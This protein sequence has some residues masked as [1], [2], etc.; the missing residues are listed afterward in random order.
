MR[1][2]TQKTEVQKTDSQSTLSLP[3]AL[4]VTPILRLERPQAFRFHIDEQIGLPLP[5]LIKPYEKMHT[6]EREALTM[7]LETLSGLIP[8]RLR[9]LEAY[10]VHLYQ[11]AQELE[12]DA[13]FKEMQKAVHIAD[14]IA[15]L[16]VLYLAIQGQFLTSH[17]GG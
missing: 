10:Y 5:H 15:E 3:T 16:N 8:E 14:T 4:D 13:F 1:A 12:G 7:A 17:P 9:E 6:E 2:H 11:S